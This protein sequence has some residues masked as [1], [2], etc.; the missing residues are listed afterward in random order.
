MQT[1]ITA[2]QYKRIATTNAPLTKEGRAYMQAQVDHLYTVFTN[3]VATNRGTTAD[4]VLQHMAD[5]HVFFGQQAIDAGLADGVFARDV[6]MADMAANPSRYAQRRKAVF[7][8]SH[9]PSKGTGAAPKD[10]TTVKGQSMTDETITRESLERD[11]A[12][13]V[14][15][16][17]SEGAKAEMERA[18]SVRALS[19]P[20]FEALIETMA[21]D[22]KTTPEQAAMALIHA[23]KQEAKAAADAHF[24]DAPAAAPAAAVT[25]QAQVKTPQ[26]LAAEIAAFVK[27]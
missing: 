24:E 3:E 23:Q 12:A 16:I 26:Q 1:E 21:G 25:D 14:A 7:A 11:H 20:G 10:T 6:L 22:G 17:K 15:Q 19:I 2:G 13:L 27:E 4:K 8:V 5:G 9:Q 18:A